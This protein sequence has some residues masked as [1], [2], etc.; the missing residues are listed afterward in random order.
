MQVFFL[1][2]PSECWIRKDTKFFGRSGGCSPPTP[3]IRTC[4]SIVFPIIVWDLFS[5]FLRLYVHSFIRKKKEIPFYAIVKYIY[6][7][8]FWQN[9]KLSEVLKFIWNHYFFF[10]RR[11]YVRKQIKVMDRQIAGRDFVVAEISLSFYSSMTFVYDKI[12]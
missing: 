6:Q 8:F 3:W 10:R 9:Y 11:Y 2:A 4:A 12:L 5:I 1:R 7:L